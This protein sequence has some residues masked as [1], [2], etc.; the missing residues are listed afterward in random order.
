MHSPSP[1]FFFPSFPPHTLCKSVEV[2]F[3]VVRQPIHWHRWCTAVACLSYPACV[4]PHK[5]QPVCG[6][7]WLQGLSVY[8]ISWG[9]SPLYCCKHKDKSRSCNEQH[10]LSPPVDI[11][12]A[13]MIVWRIRGKLSEL[14]CAVACTTVVHNDM[15]THE[16]FLKMNV[17]FGLGLVFVHLFRFSILCVFLF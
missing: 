3:F 6:C 9:Q 7:L 17:G 1:S 8:S 13:M 10:L 11:I 5:F 2:T 4:W 16:Q 15:H 12:W 14:F